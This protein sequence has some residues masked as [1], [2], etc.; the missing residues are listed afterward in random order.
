MS[1]AVLICCVCPAR[2]SIHR[3]LDARHDL[4]QILV[5]QLLVRAARELEYTK[6]LLGTSADRVA[7]GILNGVS[8]GRGNS[9]PAVSQVIDP[10]YSGIALIQ[11]LRDTEAK[12]LAM[13]ARFHKLEV[14]F[15]PSFVSKAGTRASIDVVTESLLAGLQQ[16][17][18]QTVHN[19][20]KTVG[21][22][23][24]PHPALA[25][26]SREEERALRRKAL[27]GPTKRRRRRRGRDEGR[28]APREGEDTSTVG[29]DSASVAAS[30]LLGSIM[31]AETALDPEWEQKRRAGLVLC[32]LCAGVLTAE[33]AAAVSSARSLKDS[34][35]Y[36]CGVLVG[37][38]D[39]HVQDGDAAEVEPSAQAPQQFAAFPPFVPAAAQKL[40][41]LE[42]DE[43]R[44]VRRDDSSP[45][46]TEFHRDMFADMLLSDAEDDGVEHTADDDAALAEIRED[47][48]EDQE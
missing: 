17:F 6:V 23:Q 8:K 33:E 24:M 29:D 43:M 11:P 26:M 20:V 16:R 36:A 47:A 38:L 2:T 45:H 44:L 18:P 13:Y 12:E 1:W 21:K 28:H 46:L 34:L 41:K 4:L 15:T 5:Q 14:R 42:R 7:N 39:L 30:E 31:T 35:C 9:L 32:P 40:V 37:E 25:V 22:L 10:R 3:T 48:G 19:I 27:G